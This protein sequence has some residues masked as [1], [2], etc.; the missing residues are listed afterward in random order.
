MRR[1]QNQ[2]VFSLDDQMFFILIL[3]S[4]IEVVMIGTKCKLPKVSLTFQMSLSLG[5]SP[6]NKVSTLTIHYL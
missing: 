1:A 4:K 2:L 3:N 5:L 6:L